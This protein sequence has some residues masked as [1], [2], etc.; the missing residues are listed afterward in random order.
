MKLNGSV[1]V[2]A[3]KIGE[4]EG[5]RERMEGS[6]GGIRVELRVGLPGEAFD[7]FIPPI[8]C[9]DFKRIMPPQITAIKHH[10]SPIIPKTNPAFVR[11][12]VASPA[13]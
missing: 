5:T 10:A 4:K 6:W 3:L 7:F 13:W 2:V 8:L 1:C 11:P 12:R 9:A